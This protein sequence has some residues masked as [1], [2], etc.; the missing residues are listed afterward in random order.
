MYSMKTEDS[1]EIDKIK[2]QNAI[3]INTNKELLEE[4]DAFK[5]SHK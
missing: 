3:L 2:T 4:L 5:N 1:K